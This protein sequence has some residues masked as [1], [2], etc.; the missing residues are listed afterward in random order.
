MDLCNEDLL[1][2]VRLW[3]SLS[4]LMQWNHSDGNEHLHF[5]WVCGVCEHLL[6][7]QSKLPKWTFLLLDVGCF[8]K[9]S[10]SC[11]LGSASTLT[12]HTISFQKHEFIVKFLKSLLFQWK[13]VKRL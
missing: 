3:G 10:K 4:V 1:I 12:K 2:E 6:A 7:F 5:A 9:W 13:L 8:A 11:S